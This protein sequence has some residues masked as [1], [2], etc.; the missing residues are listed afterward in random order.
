MTNNTE[1]GSGRLGCDEGVDRDALVAY[2]DHLLDAST[3]ADWCPNGLQVEGRARIQRLITGVSACQAL[4]DQAHE[5]CADAVLVHH[6][7]FWNGAPVALIGVLGRRVRTLINAEINLFAYH[8]PLDRHRIYGNNAVAARAFGLIDIE[9]F[10]EAKGLPVGVCGRLEDPIPSAEL[11]ARSE[12]IYAQRPLHFPGGPEQVR[13]I[14]IVS[15]AGADAVY[16]A[17]EA[18]LDALVT[19]EPREW[20]MSL[21]REAGIHVLAAGHHATERLGARALGEHLGEAFGLEVRFIDIPNP[22]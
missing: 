6:G 20:L 3:G 10:A 12:R 7:L 2:L 14:G 11:V 18:G 4:F 19:G 13:T 21:A 22:A 15:G 8:L 1:P 9:P 17:L 16:P 5:A